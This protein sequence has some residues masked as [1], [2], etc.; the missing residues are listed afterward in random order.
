MYFAIGIVAG[1]CAFA[2]VA[3]LVGMLLPE[4]HAASRTL[5][6]KRPPE[7][8][9]QAVT[10]GVSASAETERHP[11]HRIAWRAAG[12]DP[13][14][15]V[16]ITRTSANGSRVTATARTERWFPLV[17]VASRALGWPARAVE[18][19]LGPLARKLGEQPKFA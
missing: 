13:R 17:R 2:L 6:L 16:E 8:V 9:W 12:G 7:E 11:P 4:Q 15:E 19:Y 14:W 10:D 1:L 5:V 3:T 18:E